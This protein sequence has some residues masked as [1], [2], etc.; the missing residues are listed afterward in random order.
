[1]A[2]P[3]DAA[4]EM[5]RI[6]EKLQ[7]QAAERNENDK[8]LVLEIFTREDQVTPEFAQKCQKWSNAAYA[9]DW[10]T[11]MLVSQIPSPRTRRLIYIYIYI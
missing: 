11:I 4:N 8:V 1:M 6:I 2:S 9:G 10:D 7:L 3:D 5:K